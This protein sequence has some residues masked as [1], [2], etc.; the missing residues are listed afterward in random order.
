MTLAPLFDSI[1]LSARNSLAVYTIERDGRIWKSPYS[2]RTRFHENRIENVIGNWQELI[3][4]WTRLKTLI[5]SYVKFHQTPDT[6]TSYE[7]VNADS[8]IRNAVTDFCVPS[9]LVYPRLL[10]IWNKATEKAL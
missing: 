2:P 8:P 7:S 5:H 1:F 6:Y 10:A 3:P 9:Q 4:E